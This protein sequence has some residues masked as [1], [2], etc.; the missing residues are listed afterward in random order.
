M[1]IFWPDDE[2]G[3]VL[4]KLSIEGFD[5]SAEYPIDF[6]IDFDDWPPPAEFVELVRQRYE[7]VE[8]SEP[9][10]GFPGYIMIVLQAQLSYE[11]VT[12]MKAELSELAEPY[13][14]WCEAWGV[15]HEIDDL[16]GRELARSA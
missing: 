6:S 12:T 10:D 16:V 7:E 11:L 1:M 15:T 3:E 14:G 8:L 4:H 13:G 9:Q 2:D 5:F